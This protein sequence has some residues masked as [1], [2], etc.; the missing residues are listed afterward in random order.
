[1]NVNYDI[2]YSKNSTAQAV[3]FTDGSVVHSFGLIF[4]SVCHSFGLLALNCFSAKC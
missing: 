1:M 4:S 2:L 3:N